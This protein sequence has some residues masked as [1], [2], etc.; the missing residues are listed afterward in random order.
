ME[1]EE[2]EFLAEK[3]II[4]MLPNFKAPVLNLMTVTVGPFNPG[5]VTKAPL[6]LALLLCE[7]NR[8]RILPPSWLN[9]ESL[10]EIRS[11]ERAAPIFTKLPNPC[12]FEISTI[13]LQKFSIE[14]PNAD[15][16]K[17]LFHDILDI[18]MAKLDSSISA[19]FGSGSAHAVVNNL[20]SFEIIRI[21]S[22][23]SDSLSRLN[24]LEMSANVNPFT[25]A[26]ASTSTSST[27]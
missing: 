4:E 25:V 17:A 20:T 18:R 21:R 9:V 26:S 16:V 5:V 3:Q 1:I 27:N 8:C 2:A 12:F 7:Q 10:T 23:L 15:A 22:F 14:V 6:W 24:T 19:F 11:A 13:I